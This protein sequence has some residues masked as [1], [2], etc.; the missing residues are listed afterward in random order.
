MSEMICKNCGKKIYRN[1]DGQWFHDDNISNYCY[2][3]KV[4]VPEE[5][6]QSY[7]IINE[8]KNYCELEYGHEEM[9]KRSFLGVDIKWK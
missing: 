8:V 4:A 6:C 5:R 1:W 2:P 7:I 3:E 9:H